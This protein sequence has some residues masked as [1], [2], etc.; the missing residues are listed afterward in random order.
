MLIVFI[1]GLPLF[2]VCLLIWLDRMRQRS[3]RKLKEISK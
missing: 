2:V 1:A 3:E